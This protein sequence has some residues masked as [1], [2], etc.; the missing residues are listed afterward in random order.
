MVAGYYFWIKFVILGIFIVGTIM[1]ESAQA[2]LRQWHIIDFLLKNS[3]YVSTN[4]IC[5]YLEQKGIDGQIRTV[6]RDLNKLQDV[7]SLECRKD[8]KP[9]SWRWRRLKGAKKHHLSLEQ[10]LILTMVEL[11][12][13]DFIPNDV[14]DR[15]EPL[16]SQARY[17]V[18]TNQLES[19][20]SAP[21][22]PKTINKKVHGI[23]PPSPYQHLTKPW[24]KLQSFVKKRQDAK[25]SGWRAVDDSDVR[26]LKA[27]LVDLGFDEVG[28]ML[29]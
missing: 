29:G 26:L 8:D 20:P 21:I 10:A 5:Y 9:Y 14:L 7:F 11:E 24:I 28:R 6:Q 25:Q 19:T 2:V 27:C 18:A 16:L 1:S 22:S 4:D 15:L 13:K 12:L 23:V 3:G 17:K